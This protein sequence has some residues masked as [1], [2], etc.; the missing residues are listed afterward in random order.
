M[1]MFRILFLWYTLI[2]Y[3]GGGGV[4]TKNPMQKHIWYHHTFKLHLVNKYK[5]KELLFIIYFFRH[6]PD[7]FIL[8]MCRPVRHLSTAFIVI[9]KNKQIQWYLLRYIV[10]LLY[11]AV[12]GVL[13]LRLPIVLWFRVYLLML[14]V[15][16]CEDTLGWLYHLTHDISVW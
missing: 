2:S 15:Q 5:R 9:L 7:R 10:V 11:C 3:G 1:F 16:R 6:Y 4:V 13:R 14:L 12:V 8:C